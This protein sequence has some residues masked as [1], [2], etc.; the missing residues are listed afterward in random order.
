MIISSHVGV[1][2]VSHK[3]IKFMFLRHFCLMKSTHP[4]YAD[5]LWVCCRQRKGQEAQ[6]QS[7]RQKYKRT[8]HKSYNFSLDMTLAN[9]QRTSHTAFSGFTFHTLL[10]Y[11]SILL[12]HLVPFWAGCFATKLSHTV[13]ASTSPARLDLFHD[14]V[15]FY[16][17]RAF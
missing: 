9:C 16:L 5:V 8:V 11:I 4:G 14:A 10:S 2:S 17:A 6:R 3:A 13:D 1:V 7:T 12:A 15:D